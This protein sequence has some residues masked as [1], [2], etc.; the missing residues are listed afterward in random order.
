MKVKVVMRLRRQASRHLCRWRRSRWVEGQMK[1]K[2]VM[3]LRRQSIRLCTSLLFSVVVVMTTLLL[4]HRNELFAGQLWLILTILYTVSQKTT[5][6]LHTTTSTQVNRLYLFLAGNSHG[7]WAIISLFNFS[8]P[9]A[10]ISLIC[11]EITMAKM[12]HLSFQSCCIPCLE[13]DTALACYIF[14]THQPI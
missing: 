14:D 6:M 2:V 4:L 13:I 3:R 9:F 8:C 12:M 7:V 5:L 11:C 1:V 10:I